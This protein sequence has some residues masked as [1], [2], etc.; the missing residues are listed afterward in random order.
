MSAIVLMKI[1]AVSSK[2]MGDPR[3]Y[4]LKVAAY[5]QD[6]WNRKEQRWE[7]SFAKPYLLEEVDL[8]SASP[9]QKA[10]EVAFQRYGKMSRVEF[11]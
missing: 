5:N 7:A 2:V 4:R 8:E 3:G 6:K 10:V 9:M 11:C 1:E